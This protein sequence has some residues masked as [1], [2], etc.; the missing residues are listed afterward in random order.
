MG[1]KENKEALPVDAWIENFIGNDPIISKDSTEHEQRVDGHHLK[2]KMEKILVRGDLVLV[3]TRS[4]D[5]KSY[6]VTQIGPEEACCCSDDDDQFER[7]VES[8]MTEDEVKKFEEDWTNL[9]NPDFT[10]FESESE[11]EIEELHQ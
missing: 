11:S 1:N 2:E 10:E 6:K 8:D 9:W 4:I 7:R 5:E 3:W